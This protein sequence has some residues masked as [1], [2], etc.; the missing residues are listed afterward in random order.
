VWSSEIAISDDQAIRS[1]FPVR[2]ISAIFGPHF[3]CADPEYRDSIYLIMCFML[4]VLR[5]AFSGFPNQGVVSISHSVRNWCH[6][7]D[8]ISNCNIIESFTAVA[9]DQESPANINVLK[10]F[11]TCQALNFPICL[12]SLTFNSKETPMMRRH[13][14]CLTIRLRRRIMVLRIQNGT[15]AS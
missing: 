14:S 11:P 5:F 3:C 2:N 10:V 13:L 15:Q 7:L 6:A 12:P 8:S 9:F 1:A 4:A